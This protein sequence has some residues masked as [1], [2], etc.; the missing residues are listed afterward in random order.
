[1]TDQLVISMFLPSYFCKLFYYA[2]KNLKKKPKSASF[3]IAFTL[4]H[5]V[6]RQFK[7]ALQCWQ[8]ADRTAVDDVL[9]RLFNV[10]ICHP[11]TAAGTIFPSQKMFIQVHL[12]LLNLGFALTWIWILTIDVMIQRANHWA[13]VAGKLVSYILLDAFVFI[14]ICWHWT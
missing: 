7:N 14:V 8:L 13:A 10:D 12:Y 2:W 11:A 9:W 1:M 5:I 4:I 6:K 3:C